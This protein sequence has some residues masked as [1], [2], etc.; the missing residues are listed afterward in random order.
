MFMS[1]YLEHPEI[2]RLVYLFIMKSWALGIKA[3][4]SGLKGGRLGNLDYIILHSRFSSTVVF[5]LL[6]QLLGN[7]YNQSTSTISQLS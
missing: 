3:S 4:F 1:Q 6:G 5:R 7:V 2:P